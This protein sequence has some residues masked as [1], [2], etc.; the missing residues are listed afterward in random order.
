M[1]AKVLI[2]IG[3]LVVAGVALGQGSSTQPAP[4]RPAGILISMDSSCPPAEVV[5]P[6]A[7]QLTPTQK[8]LMKAAQPVS[9]KRVN[10]WTGAMALMVQVAAMGAATPPPPPPAGAVAYPTQA[11]LDCAWTLQGLAEDTGEAG[12]GADIAD[13]GG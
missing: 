13:Y 11:A 3:L 1:K 2:P 8:T 10:P 4:S 5:P 9:L 12:E 6:E 7:E